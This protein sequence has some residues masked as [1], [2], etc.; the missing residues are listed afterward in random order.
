MIMFAWGKKKLV[1]CQ[2][3]ES[4]FINVLIRYQSEALQAA[5]SRW[6]EDR[7]TESRVLV[8]HTAVYICQHL[9]F[10]YKQNYDRI[11]HVTE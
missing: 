7:S 8:D 5:A 4:M 1:P 3:S 2:V 6:A 10:P 9:L 11:S